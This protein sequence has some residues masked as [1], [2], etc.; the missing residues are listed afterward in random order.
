MAL[1]RAAEHVGLIDHPDARKRH[2]DPVPLLGGIAIVLGIIAGLMVMPMIWPPNEFRALI[3]AIGITAV[4]GVLDDLH[5]IS[6]RVKLMFQ[7]AA[8][9]LL[10]AWAGISL[11]SLGAVITA[12]TPIIT[13]AWSIPFTLLAGVGLMNAVNMTDGLDGLVGSSALLTLGTM[14]VLAAQS[15]TGAV[16]MPLLLL[17]C[18]TLVGFLIFNLPYPGRPLRTFLGDTGSLV[19]G[20]L[21]TWFAVTLSQHP[22][23]VAPP[24]VFVWLCGL[25]LVDFLCI[26]VQRAVRRRNPLAADRRHWH[27]LLQRAGLSARMTFVALVT[28]HALLCYAGVLMWKLGLS[29]AAMLNAAIGVLALCLV[30]TLM[31]RRWIRWFRRRRGLA[32]QQR[33]IVGR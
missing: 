33:P 20:L 7:F 29:E 1:R 21:I 19:L 22:V 26:M 24:I 6:A 28:V 4:A 5:E 32:V 23:N 16:Y 27:H 3:G 31:A 11:Q 13:G 25:F 18:A 10:T 12:G 15:P 8:G 30:G 2:G 17:A 9:A 14:G